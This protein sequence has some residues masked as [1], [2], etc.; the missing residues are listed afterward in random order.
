LL[1]GAAACVLCWVA[2]AGCG[3]RTGFL[4]GD[5]VGSNL[6]PDDDVSGNAGSGGSAGSAGS[7]GLGLGGGSSMPGGV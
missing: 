1:G 6:L 4:D 3:S 2:L 7:G 5:G